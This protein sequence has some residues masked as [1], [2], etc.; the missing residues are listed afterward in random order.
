MA[1][2]DL[3]DLREE[4][5]SREAG[6]DVGGTRLD[7]DSDERQQPLLTPWGRARS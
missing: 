6:E 5:A 4:L 7:P 2:T 3:V 1:N